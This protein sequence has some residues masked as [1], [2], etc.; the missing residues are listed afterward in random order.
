MTLGQG[1]DTPLGHGQQLSEILSRS[2]LA[3]RSYG[4]DTDFQYV[5]TVTLTLEIGQ[6]STKLWPEHGFPV[7]VHCDLDLG[8]M[9]LG[10]GHDTPLGHGQQLC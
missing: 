6:G 1:H 7:C 10:Q 9:T 5:C 4:P 8:D 3:V 2:N